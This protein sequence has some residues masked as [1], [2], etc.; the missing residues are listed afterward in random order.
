MLIENT[1]VLKYKKKIEK[2]NKTIKNIFSNNELDGKVVVA[3]NAQT[4]R[5]ILQ[6]KIKAGVRYK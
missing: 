5:N 4:T 2:K 1:R 3:K 6:F